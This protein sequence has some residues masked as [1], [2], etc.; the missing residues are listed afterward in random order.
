MAEESD[1]KEDI[2]HKRFGHLG[3]GSLQRL[4]REKFADGFD[5]DASQKLKFCETCPLGKQHRTK[6]PSSS[7]RADEPFDLVHSDLCGKVN[8]KS[9]SGAEYFLS[10]IDDKTRYV[11]SYALS[12]KDQVFEKFRE[13]KTLIEKSTGRR[14]KTFRSDNGGE[15]TSKEFESYLKAE[16][17]RH[18]L[19]IPNNPEQNGVAERMNRTLV[20]TVRS[21]LVNSNLPC[22]FWAEALSTATYLRNRSPTKAVSGMTP[23]EA[24]T[25]IKPQVGGLRV[26]GCQAFVH[27]PKEERK[28]LEVKSR[29]CVLLGYGSTT[30]G[31]RLYDPQ[32]GKVFHSRDVIFN[33]QKYGLDES[34]EPQKEPESRVNLEYSDEPLETVDSPAPPPRRSERERRQPSYFGF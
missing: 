27:I 18:E 25:G 11:W 23:Y 21:M 32:K 2:W 7:T 19:T 5:F 20:E 13:W 15:F 1:S 10:F 29:K 6:F 31:Y 26:F 34:S 8:V 12:R 33:E 17:I 30:K 24:W 9:E 3:V 4:A 14:L 16:G 28:K 22:T